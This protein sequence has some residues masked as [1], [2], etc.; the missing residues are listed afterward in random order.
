MELRKIAAMAECHHIPVCPHNPSGPI[1]NAATL[2]LAACVPNFYLMETM[3]SD[4]SYRKDLTTED[5]RFENG[6]MLIS[7]KPGLG[8]DL[9]PEAIAEYP[10]TPHILQHYDGNLTN[11]RPES[12]KT[13]FN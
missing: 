7:N 11:I 13:Y 8:I 4:V 12:S 1:A 10:Y 5:V 9:C 2:Q 6:E 3:S